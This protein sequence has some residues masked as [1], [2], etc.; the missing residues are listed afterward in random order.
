MLVFDHSALLDQ[1]RD[2]RWHSIVDALTFQ[3]RL[4]AHTVVVDPG[5]SALVITVR[6]NDIGVKLTTGEQRGQYGWVAST[7]AHPL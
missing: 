5:T 1:Y 3:D 2:H 6:G 7:D 4:T